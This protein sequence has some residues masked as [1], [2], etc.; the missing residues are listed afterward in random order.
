MVDPN[1]RSG[2]LAPWLRYCRARARGYLVHQAAGRCISEFAEEVAEVR[3]RMVRPAVNYAGR[4]TAAQSMVEPNCT[5]VASD[6]EMYRVTSTPL[7]WD[8]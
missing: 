7:H 2:G 4:D 6:V 1:L 5:V 3:F 8:L